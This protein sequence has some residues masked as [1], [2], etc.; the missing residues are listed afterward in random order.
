MSMQRMGFGVCL[1][2]LLT[3]SNPAPL[4]ASRICRI[5]LG[6]PAPRLL[7]PNEVLRVSKNGMAEFRWR[8]VY[9][10][11][12][13]YYDFRIYEGTK[14]VQSTLIFKSRVP[15]HQDSIQVSANLFVEGK[16]YAWSV[17]SATPFTKS[18]SSYSMFTV[19]PT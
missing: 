17:R 4:E 3:L 16:L 15:L 19:K 10:P 6:Y 7:S 9:L 5:M 13:A 1:L 8:P 12:G 2:L 11:Y 14:L 18:A